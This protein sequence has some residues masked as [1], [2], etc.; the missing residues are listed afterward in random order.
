MNPFPAVI[1]HAFFGYAEVNKNSDSLQ[2]SSELV[3]M[4]KRN[5]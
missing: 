5:V 2:F 3:L 4:K 1:G